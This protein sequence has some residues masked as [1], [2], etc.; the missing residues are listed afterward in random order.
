MSPK[1]NQRGVR[2]G[3]TRHPSLLLPGHLPQSLCSPVLCASWTIPCKRNNL[4]GSLRQQPRPW[5]EMGRSSVP[6]PGHC[7]SPR[8]ASPPAT[9]KPSSGA[10]AQRAPQRHPPARASP[11]HGAQAPGSA[12]CMSFQRHLS[13]TRREAQNPGASFPRWGPYLAVAVLPGWDTS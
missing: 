8:R 9:R 7:P 3:D 10:Q 11:R 12:S 1:S 4:G 6:A 2:V 13:H 5:G